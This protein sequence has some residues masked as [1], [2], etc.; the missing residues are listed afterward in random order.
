M[1]SIMWMIIIWFSEHWFKIFWKL[2]LCV[3][4]QYN[5]NA[6]VFMILSI[7]S[8]LSV[9]NNGTVW[10]LYLLHVVIRTALFCSLNILSDL[11]PHD[12]MQY[13][14][15]GRIK[16]LYKIFN[17]FWDTNRFNLHIIPSDLDIRFDIFVHAHSMSNAD[18]LSNLRNQNQ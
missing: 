3:S 14:R 1:S 12:N 2:I 7:L 13:C 17:I 11:K 9:F 6:F 16:L 4:L 8:R 5:Y 10:A 15:W 18:R